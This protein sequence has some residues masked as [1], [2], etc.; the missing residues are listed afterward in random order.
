MDLKVYRLN[1]LPFP[2]D[3]SCLSAEERNFHP[4][5]QAARALLRQELQQRLHIPA[6]DIRFFFNE[7][8][9]PMVNGQHF[10]IS[11]AGDCLCMAF[12]HLAVGVDVEQ[13]KPRATMQKMAARFMGDEQ[14]TAFKYRNCPENDFFACWC[15]AEALV[16]HAG[17][18]IF[19]ARD[20]PFLHCDGQIKTL[21]ANAPHVLLFTPLP[22]Y[23]GAVA[24][25]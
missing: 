4:R 7:H 24:F 8:G 1:A 19:Q 14:L 10:N 3:F 22:G 11:H 2:I 15:T 17:K 9:K 18:S 6:A 5:R 23:C 25:S 12:H 21:Y 20:Y 13:I 16:K